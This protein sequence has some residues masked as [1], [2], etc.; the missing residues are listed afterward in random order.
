LYR[1]SRQSAAAYEEALAN[2]TLN[3]VEVIVAKNRTG[4]TGI[5]KLK[6]HDHYMRFADPQTDSLESTAPGP[7]PF[8]N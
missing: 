2:D 7:S 3:D 4:K 5:T 1:H 8:G 6:F